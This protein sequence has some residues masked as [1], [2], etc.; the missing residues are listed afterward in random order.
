VS[1]V[2]I[3]VREPRGD[4]AYPRVV[5]A[6]SLDVEEW[7]LCP[8]VPG[9]W[10]KQIKVSNTYALFYYSSSPAVLPGERGINT[11]PVMLVE[12]ILDV[13]FVK[14]QLSQAVDIEDQDVIEVVCDIEW[15]L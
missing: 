13:F 4:D 11:G 10:S 12:S 1:I 14:I 9:P 3:P 8:S 15:L 7:P 2:P 5:M 6:A